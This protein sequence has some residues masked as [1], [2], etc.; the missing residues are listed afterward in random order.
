MKRR[1]WF[2]LAVVVAL[3]L[4]FAAITRTIHHHAKEAP[5]VHSSI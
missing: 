5:R 3:E 4:V 2:V 1:V